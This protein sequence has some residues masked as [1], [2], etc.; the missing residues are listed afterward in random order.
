MSTNTEREELAR[1]ATGAFYESRSSLRAMT[2]VLRL[3]WFRVADAILAAGYSKATS[4][5]LGYVVLNQYGGLVVGEIFDTREDA[6]ARAGEW[7][8]DPIT[9]TPGWDY[10]VAEIVE[11]TR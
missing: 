10:R 2:S 9:H 6:M 8:A 5:P 7:A 4:L 11:P 3:A 1:I